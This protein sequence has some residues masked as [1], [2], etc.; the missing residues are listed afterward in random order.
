VALLAAYLTYAHTANWT[1]YYIEAF[2]IIVLLTARGIVRAGALL[3][4]RAALGLPILV[5]CMLIE[6]LPSALSRAANIQREQH[7]P[8][9]A[10]RAVLARLP[11]ER[12]IVFVRYG[13]HHDVHQSVIWNPPF[14]ERARIWVVYDRGADNARLAAMYPDRALYLYDEATDRLA[15]LPA[16]AVTR[17]RTD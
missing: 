3:G 13:S 1:L 10:F 9:R 8:Q 2:P 4:S 12:A 17:L 7:G 5:A 15:R 16:G 11:G 6:S 14:L